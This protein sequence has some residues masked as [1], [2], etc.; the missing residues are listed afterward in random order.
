MG[1][2]HSVSLIIPMPYMYLYVRPYLHV[3]HRRTAP[4]LHLFAPSL[5]CNDR[6][7]GQTVHKGSV[8]RLSVKRREHEL[9]I[10]AFRRLRLQFALE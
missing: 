7:T 6:V 4:E 9:I 8:T 2:P 10:G 3:E 5:Q 1:W